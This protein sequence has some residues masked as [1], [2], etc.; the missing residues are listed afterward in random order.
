MCWLLS[1][2][3]YIEHVLAIILLQL[4]RT[5]VGYYL[6]T[7][8]QNMCWLLS[9][10]NYIEHVL[11]IILLQLYRTCVGYYLITII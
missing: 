5:C 1:Y 3:N 11:A 9:Y 2:K 10:Y 8:I 7:I 4:Y 6:I